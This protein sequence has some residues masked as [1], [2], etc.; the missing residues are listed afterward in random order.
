MTLGVILVYLRWRRRYVYFN[1]KHYYKYVH[2]LS[3]Y[4]SHCTLHYIIR[5]FIILNL[6]RYYIALKICILF[7][8]GVLV[9]SHPSL[10]PPGTRPPD[11]TFT[12]PHPCTSPFTR[13]GTRPSTRP[14]ALPFVLP[15][16]QS[17]AHPPTL[18]PYTSPPP[19][20]CQGTH[21]SPHPPFTPPLAW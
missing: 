19:S 11:L 15:G 12:P 9:R 17:F 5:K 20:V 16:T 3:V 1:I 7:F 13:T 14:S 4:N 2:N 10:Y 6:L 8:P 21:P 18:P